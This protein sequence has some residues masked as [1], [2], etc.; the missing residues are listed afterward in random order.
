MKFARCAGRLSRGSEPA[1]PAA[2][3]TELEKLTFL[4]RLDAHQLDLS[5]L[6]VERRRALA[7]AGRRATGQSLQRK[8]EQRRYPI[9]LTVLAQSAVDVLDDLLLLF[10]QAISGRESHAEAKL[11]EKL[12][13]RA[14]SGEDRQALLDEILAVLLDTGMDDEQVGMLIRNGIGMER[15][16]AARAEAK[17]RL[18]RDHGHLRSWTGR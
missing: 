13:E 18:P 11:R 17:P 5:M 1:P 15:L 8:E 4:R 10:D 12:A 7:T 3:K 14:E 9:L 6:P 2:V 16:R